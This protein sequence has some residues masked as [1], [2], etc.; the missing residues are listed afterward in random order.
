[1]QVQN[2]WRQFKTVVEAQWKCILQRKKDLNRSRRIPAWLTSE[3]RSSKRA[4]KLTSSIE[5]VLPK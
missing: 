3:V 5:E 1:M 2:V 4:R